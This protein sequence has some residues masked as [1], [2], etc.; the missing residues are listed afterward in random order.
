[1][2]GILRQRFFQ[3]WI[4]IS[5]VLSM[6]L[7]AQ[8][9]CEVPYTDVARSH[10]GYGYVQVMHCRNLMKGITYDQ[11][12]G[13]QPLTRFQLARVLKSLLARLFLF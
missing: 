8:A 3:L 1:M 2:I 9:N 11:F 4:S 7:S 6:S 5:L 13:N 10:W 12:G